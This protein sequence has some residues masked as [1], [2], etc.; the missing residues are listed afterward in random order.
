MPDKT[1]TAQLLKL[2]LQSVLDSGGS[3]KV[4]DV[5]QS[6]TDSV[7]FSDHELS[8][9]N[10]GRIRWRTHLRFASISLVKANWIEKEKGNWIITESGKTALNLADA[11]FM[12][13][14]GKAYR[15]WYDEERNS[16]SGQDESV[17]SEA[18]ADFI[19]WAKRFY[20]S[21]QFKEEITYKVD[22]AQ[23]LI[24]TRE[25]FLAGDNWIDEL[26]G[27][28]GPPNNLTPWRT[29][30]R[31]LSLL[32]NDTEL[33]TRA[34][35][36]VWRTKDVNSSTRNHEII[37][38]DACNRM[39]AFLSIL[40]E[41]TSENQNM[42]EVIGSFLMMGVNHLEFPLYRA[43]PFNKA[44]R[45]TK[46]NRSAKRYSTAMDRYE[47]AINFASDFIIRCE[48]EDLSGLNFLEAQSLIWCVTKGDPFP[49]WSKADVDAFH[50]F[51]EGK[52]L[53]GDAPE[54]DAQVNYW[55]V[56]SQV[57]GI[58]EQHRFI[59]E[60]IW[61]C[62][63]NASGN[64]IVKFMEPGDRI[65]IRELS[66]QSSDLPFRIS[67][68]KW[69][70]GEYLSK[71]TI[72]AI[73]TITDNFSDGHTVSVNW[74]SD[75]E[76]KEWYGY[77]FNK[78]VWCLD[79]NSELAQHLIK[80]AFY[81]VPQDYALFEKWWNQGDSEDVIP[82]QPYTVEDIIAEGVFI[83]ADELEVIIDRLQDKSNLILQ[84]APGVGKTFI[85]KKLAYALIGMKD[86]N[87]VETIQLH[88][89][90]SYEDFIRGFRPTNEAGKFELKDGPFIQ[91]CEKASNDPENTY[92]LI[93]DEI[94]RGNLSQIFGEMF[95]LLESDKRGVNNEITPL[96][97]HNDGEKIWVP[98]N[99]FLIGTMNI[100][101][102]SL[103]LVDYALRRRFAFVTLTPRFS[104]DSF[105]QWLL[106]R[107]MGA[108]IVDRIVTGM[109]NLND[110]ITEDSQLGSA[111]QIGHSFFCPR[112]EDFSELG[113]SW[114]ESV[115]KTEIEPLLQEYWF[116][117]PVQASQTMN[118]VFGI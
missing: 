10:S 92:V 70:A 98:A 102:R 8:V 67:K 63:D 105:R 95:S 75:N 97:R 60:G 40:S 57:N 29:H 11:E 41:S 7:S 33:V 30:S 108:Q 18:W 27:T 113:D 22:I 89:S 107:N 58:D 79:K 115:L 116:D 36:A 117:E 16:Q 69:G 54:F 104:D 26:R 72:T 23:K 85:A 101:D 90:Y 3:A 103:A 86:D 65:A 20:E 66:R 45:L 46:E 24:R 15:D 52:D 111:Y 64:E 13:E 118:D 91:L 77:T 112:G 9:N 5:F 14:S 43:D 19:I 109:N 80:F 106:D 47:R 96:Y 83:S 110:I 114:F 48:D 99:L 25:A 1:R 44:Y 94:N 51:R 68:R 78:S 87:F 93:I 81:N 71:F 4:S 61:E 2:A 37:I 84:G 55:M 12:E 100:A 62:G 39:R 34:L 6:L 35:A 21:A 53:S 56:S 76:H 28:F 73:G 42:S 74:E 32:N 17:S 59:E 49:T 88:P 31:F 38:E 82:P 50:I